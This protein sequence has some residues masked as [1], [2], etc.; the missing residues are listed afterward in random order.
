[1]S[2]LNSLVSVIMSV[3]NENEVFLKESIE[4]ILNQTYKNIEYI[5]I[6][7]APENK[8]I[9]D[10]I[11]DYV[12]KDSR[13]KMFINPSNVGLAMSLNN[14]LKH[15]KGD[16]IARMD[17][18]DIS[19]AKRIEKELEFLYLNK[20]FDIV[21]TSRIDINEKGDE[22]ETKQLIPKDDICLEKTLAYASIITHPSVMLRRDAYMKVGGY[23]NYPSGQDYDLWLRLKKIGCKFHFI[24]EPLIK[25]RIRSNSISRIQKR[26]QILCGIYTRM[27]N[28]KNKQFCLDDF[29]DFIKKKQNEQGFCKYMNLLSSLEDRKIVVYIKLV[30][31]FFSNSYTREGIIKSLN[32]RRYVR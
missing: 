3:Y 17:A 6:V 18:D 2:E 11:E 21:C 15:S 32:L 7:D 4:S 30:W 19:N 14:A 5:I 10:Q 25:Y 23:N 1:M 16:F 13:V 24:D 27:M 20:K 12:K 29:L 31:M 28:K 9:I 22:L 8:K 26:T